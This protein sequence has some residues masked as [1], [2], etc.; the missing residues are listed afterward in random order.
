[1]VGAQ[2][3]KQWGSLDKITLEPTKMCTSEFIDF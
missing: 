3:L 2:L 1:M